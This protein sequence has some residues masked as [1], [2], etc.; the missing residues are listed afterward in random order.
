MTTAG[1]CFGGVVCNVQPIVAVIYRANQQIAYQF[2]G[3]VYV[4]IEASPTGYDGL[5]IGADGCDMGGCQTKVSGTL[6]AVPVVNGLASFK[7]VFFL[8][9]SSFTKY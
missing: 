8:N 9:A 3:S 4:N 7:V 5:Y 2:N 1:Q 6:A